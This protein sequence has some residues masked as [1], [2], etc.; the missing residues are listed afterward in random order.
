MRLFAMPQQKIPYEVFLSRVFLRA[1]IEFIHH[2]LNLAE[3]IFS[4]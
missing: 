1:M 2:R 4:K 3:A